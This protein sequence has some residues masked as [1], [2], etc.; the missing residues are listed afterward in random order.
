M[1]GILALLCIVV[2]LSLLVYLVVSFIS[3]LGQRPCEM[4]GCTATLREVNEFRL[5]KKCRRIAKA[6]TT[7]VADLMAQTL[8]ARSANETAEQNLKADTLRLWLTAIAVLVA[9]VMLGPS[10]VNY[11][12]SNNGKELLSRVSEAVSRP[13]LPVVVTKRPSAVGEGMVLVFDNQTDHQIT[14]G[15]VIE[16]DGKTAGNVGVTVP[17]NGSK[18]FGWAEGWAFRKGDKVSLSHSEYRDEQILLD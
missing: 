6:S 16:R 8:A 10:I 14:V 15:V 5:C 12:R 13:P 11:L 18:E 2:S 1:D 17:P 9:G 3:W 7:P 4:C